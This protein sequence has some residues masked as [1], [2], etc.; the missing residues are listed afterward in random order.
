V[1]E[2]YWE[3]KR[4][5]MGKYDGAMRTLVG[6]NPQALISF[7]LDGA[8]YEGALEHKMTA[9]TLEVDKLYLVRWHGEQ[10]LLHLEFQV[11]AIATMP[12]RMWEYNTL[13]DIVLGKPV[14]SIVLYMH[15]KKTI[16][17]PIYHRSLPDGQIIHSFAFQQ[18]KFWEIPTA[19]FEQ[20]GLE[21][22]LPL[23][24]LTKDGH[25][26]ATLERMIRGLVDAGLRDLV[27]TGEALAG[28]VFTSED[29]KLWLKERFN[30]MLH[31]ILQESWV[32]QDVHREGKQEGKQ[33]TL[34]TKILKFVKARFPTLLTQ[35]KEALARES[36]PDQLDATL[37]KLF[38]V[39]TLQ[40]A[41]AVLQQHGQHH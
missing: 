14:Y 18:V 30:K 1:E 24:P 6:N 12:R 13:A 9:R 7:L 16:P 3:D 15:K 20:P 35:A 37:D 5:T 25:N 33:E 40:E 2:K 21:P 36:D 32:Y 38:E 8:V 29:E 27:W 22:L 4:D 11:N 31:E 26:Y 34:Q 28:M 23:L 41:T 10:I 17:E 39:Q 19:T